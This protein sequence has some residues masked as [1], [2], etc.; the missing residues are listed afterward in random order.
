M[1]S[2]KSV[3]QVLGVAPGGAVGQNFKLCSE[4][5]QPLLPPLFKAHGEHLETSPILSI[6]YCSQ[7]YVHTVSFA[8]LS[9]KNI[10]ALFKLYV[11]TVSFAFLSIENGYVLFSSTNKAVANWLWPV[12]EATMCLE[13]L[14]TRRSSIYGQRKLLLKRI[15]L[16][17]N[18]SADFVIDLVSGCNKLK[19]TILTLKQIKNTIASIKPC[20]QFAD[21]L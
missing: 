17:S 5:L 1:W 12:T 13:Y 21:S 11:Q 10:Y 9:I 19:T 6:L 8:F 14:Q 18:Q 20:T 4:K 3:C 15:C 2:F 7:L 16:A